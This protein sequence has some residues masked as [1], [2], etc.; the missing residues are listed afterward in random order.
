[1][2]VDRS[3]YIFLNRYNKRNLLVWFSTT[4]KQLLNLTPVQTIL[5]P[6]DFLYKMWPG[7]NM[8]H[9]SLDPYQYN[10]ITLAKEPGVGG[11]GAELLNIFP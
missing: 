5:W 8:E 3:N 1:M 6:P 11:G 7:S 9:W 4:L 2:V 10:E